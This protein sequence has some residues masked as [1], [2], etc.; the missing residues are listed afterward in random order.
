MRGD[1]TV[2]PEGFRRVLRNAGAGFR[3]VSGLQCEKFVLLF[4]TLNKDDEPTEID[5]EIIDECEKINY[6]P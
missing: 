5:D 6:K 2:S 1:A 4:S 3:G